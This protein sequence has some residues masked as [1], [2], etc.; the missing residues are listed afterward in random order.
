MRHTRV[1]GDLSAGLL[2]YV[3]ADALG[4]LS[5]VGVTGLSYASASWA[6]PMATRSL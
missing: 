5:V 3:G 4:H 2:P 6:W 1:C